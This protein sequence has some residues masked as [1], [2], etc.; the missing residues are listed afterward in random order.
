MLVRDPLAPR[1]LEGKPARDK[2]MGWVMVA[3]KVGVGEEDGLGE[4]VAP[5][6]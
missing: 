1:T 2:D 3:S 4:G 5:Q 6:G